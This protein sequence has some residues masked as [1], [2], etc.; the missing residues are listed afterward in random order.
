MKDL[1]L[2]CI[3]FNTFKFFNENFPLYLYDFYKPSGQ[4]QIKIF[5][6]KTKSFVKEY[7]FWPK[8]I[9]Y[10]TPTIWNNLHTCL[11]L[12]NSLNSFKHGVKEYFFKKL[13]NKEHCLLKQC[14]SHQNL[15]QIAVWYSEMFLLVKVLVLFLIFLSFWDWFNY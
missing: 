2:I 5:R 14:V 1:T 12:S 3:C 15:F 11:K 4:D 9:T 13:K 8:H 10:L 6:F 7:V